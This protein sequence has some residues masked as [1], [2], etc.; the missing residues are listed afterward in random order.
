MTNLKMAPWMPSILPDSTAGG[1]RARSSRQASGTAATRVQVFGTD[2]ARTGAA[3]TGAIRAA[4]RAAHGALRGVCGAYLAAAIRAGN[5]AIVTYLTLALGT[6]V[7]GTRQANG[8]RAIAAWHGAVRAG[9]VIV[10]TLPEL[11][12]RAAA[13]TIGTL[14]LFRSLR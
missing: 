2:G 12:S 14:R 13:A 1:H 4:N 11:H 8:P 6:A 9:D 10:Q 3:L 7:Q 5:A